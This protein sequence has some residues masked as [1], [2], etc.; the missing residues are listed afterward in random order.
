MS[1]TRTPALPRQVDAVILG[2]GAGGLSLAAHLVAGGWADRRVLVV[3]DGLHP[4]RSWAYWSR[5]DG[6]LDPAASP[7][8][9]RLRVDGPGGEQVVALD[10][11][12]YRTLTGAQLRGASDRLATGAPGFT[13]V[14]GTVVRIDE[15]PTAPGVL[16]SRP[17]PG[18]PQLASVSARWVFDST[19]VAPG[20]AL[21]APRA[22]LR[23]LG[24]HVVTDHDAFDPTTPTLMDFRTDQSRG[25]AF[26]YV[27]PTSAR[28]ALVEY[29]RFASWPADRTASRD[30]EL[31]EHVDTYLRRQLGIDAFRVVGS[32]AGA[33]PLVAAAPPRP[34]GAVVRIGTP[35]GMVKASTGYGFGRI[36]RHSAAIARSLTRHGHPHDVPG[37]GRWHRSLDALLLEVVRDDPTTMPAVFTRL[38]A[39]NPGDAVLAFLDETASMRQ[40]LGLYRSLP[41]APFRRAVTRRVTRRP[42]A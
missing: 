3:D 16:I 17:G 42:R 18:D 9:T 12:R 21:P 31:G 7:G 26:V 38:F 10:E 32:E 6:L 28:T 8:S 41:I 2:G 4:D 13:R 27:L 22:G 37:P 1:P 14:R 25:V 29:T 39:A 40:E 36:Q 35:A 11:F 5:G 34:R 30:R 15:H 23:F 33:I 20:P 19:G 24:H